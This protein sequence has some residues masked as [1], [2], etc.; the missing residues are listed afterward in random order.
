MQYFKPINTIH[1]R[2]FRFMKYTCLI[3]FA[4]ICA[5]GNAFAQDNW[6]LGTQKEGISVY[7]AAV[8]NSKFKAIK[9]ECELDANLSQVVAVLMDVNT[10]ADWIY[11]VKSAK[12]VKQISAAELYYYCEVSIPF[13]FQNRDFVAHLNVHQDASNGVVTID[14]PTVAGYVPLKKDIVRVIDSDGKWTLTPANGKVK[15]VYTL[16]T[17]PGGNIPA[18]LVNLFATD[19][20]LQSIR[21]LKQQIKKPAY[22][23]ATY[24]FIRN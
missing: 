13:P 8:P 3:V 1:L 6:K 19:G 16:H 9:V 24:P 22:V 23:N 11:H 15:L 21:N 7:T 14:G 2:F 12:I 4:L 10:S 18:W 17:D 20:P 5:A